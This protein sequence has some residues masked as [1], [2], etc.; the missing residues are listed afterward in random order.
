LIEENLGVQLAVSL[1]APDDETRRKLIPTAKRYGSS[2][3]SM[4]RAATRRAAAGW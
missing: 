3:S 1:H 4:P 2:K